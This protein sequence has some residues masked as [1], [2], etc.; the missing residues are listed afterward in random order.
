MSAYITLRCNDCGDRCSED[1]T[2]RG[3][4]HA[5]RALGWI[6]RRGLDLCPTCRAKRT[7]P[8]EDDN[9]YF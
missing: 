6:C 8:K 5:A 2:H 9:G 4:R 1:K 3:A 7:K